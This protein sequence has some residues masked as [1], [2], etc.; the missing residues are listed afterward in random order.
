MDGYTHAFHPK[1]FVWC[2]RSD[3]P[4]LEAR[5][6]WANGGGRI[7]DMTELTLKGEIKIL[8]KLK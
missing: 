3:S 5:D 4:F 8:N 1:P 7:S 2:R 6:P